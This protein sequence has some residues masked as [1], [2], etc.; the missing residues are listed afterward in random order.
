MSVQSKIQKVQTALTGISNLKVYHYFAPSETKLPYCVW[1]E[2]GEAG[3]L[4]A[5]NHK[6]EQA[7]SGWIEYYTKT[8]FDPMVDAIQTALVG[9]EGLGFRY[10]NAVYGDP[11]SEDNNTIHHSWS[12]EVY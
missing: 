6:R 5:D 10:E 7:L 12:W 2:D 1:Y 4:E 9:V 3:S 11:R 8:E